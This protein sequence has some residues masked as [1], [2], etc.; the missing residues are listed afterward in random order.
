MCSRTDLNA[1]GWTL[2]RL[3]AQLW[4][5]DKKGSSIE[6]QRHH[7]GLQDLESSVVLNA[8]RTWERGDHL[9]VWEK[10]DFALLYNALNLQVPIVRRLFFASGGGREQWGKDSHESERESCMRSIKEQMHQDMR[11]RCPSDP[12]YQCRKSPL[13][14]QAIE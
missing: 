1:L 2:P 3:A 4:G 8:E 10:I 13:F 7:K 6:S 12:K 11:G 14:G 9:P 5:S